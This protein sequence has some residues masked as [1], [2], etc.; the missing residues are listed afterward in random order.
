[1]ALTLK[2]LRE[3]L[4]PPSEFVLS[5]KNS[6]YLRQWALGIGLE[7]VKVYAL[8]N[9]ELTNLY[10]ERG[11]EENSQL[12]DLQLAAADI[13]L[14]LNQTM[15]ATKIDPDWLRNLIQEQIEKLPARRIEIVIPDRPNVILDGPQHKLTETILRIASIKHPIMLVGPA[16]CGKTTIGMQISTA[17]ST[18]FYITSTINEPHDLTGFI[19]G[20]GTYHRTPFRDAFEH[21]GI[22][23]ADEIDA[24]DAAALLAANSALAQGMCVFPDNPRPIMRHPEFRVIA[25]ANTFGHGADRIYIGRN[26]LDAAS[27]DRFAV[28]PIDYDVDLERMYADGNIKWLTRVWAIRSAVKINKIRHVVSSRAIINGSMALAAGLSQEDVEEFYLFKGMSKKDRDRI[29]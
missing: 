25:T 21:G 27:L 26:E 5:T 23:V 2:Q 22:W 28:I 12:T 3:R 14:R 7:P 15:M 1:M 20:Y 9:T 24:W 6:H 18:P 16:G 8:T 19:N 13:F 17:L 11:D 4:G 29:E 10:H